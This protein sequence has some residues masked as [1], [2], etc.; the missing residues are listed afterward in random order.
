MRE[1]ALLCKVSVGTAHRILTKE[2][3]VHK[4]A[5]R[6]I[7]RILTDNQKQRRLQAA[8]NNLQRLAAEPLLLHNIITGDESWVHV[9]EPNVK[10]RDMVW[11]GPQEQRPLK[12]LR[13]CSTKKV[14][15]TAFFDDTACIHHEYTQKSIN[16]YMYTRILG[17][18]HEKLRKKRPGMWRQGFGREHA[19]ILLHNNATPHRALHT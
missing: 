19:I 7:P 14:M 2:F 10:Q 18:L 4:I 6:F 15:L 1:I 17:R 11:I 3:K 8:Q 16:R 5:S 13:R 12:A 9:Y